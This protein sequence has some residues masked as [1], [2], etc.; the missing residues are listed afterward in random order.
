M[1]TFLTVVLYIL[2]GLLII[3]AAVALMWL[4]LIVVDLFNNVD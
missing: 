2:Q 4:A 1:D 3:G